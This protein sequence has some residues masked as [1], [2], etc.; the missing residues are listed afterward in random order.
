[1]AGAPPARMK[2]ISMSYEETPGASA[3]AAPGEP[4]VIDADIDHLVEPSNPLPPG[5]LA[6]FPEL[7]QAN[8][9]GAGWA[10]LM[11]VQAAAVPYLL[12]GDRD[13]MVQSRTGS[14]KTGAFVM[15]ILARLDPAIPH[16]QAL[17][18]VPTRELAV[19]VAREA[20]ILGAGMGL[21]VVTV[22][23]GVG[24]GTQLDGFKVGAHLV[25][26]TPGRILDHLMKRSLDFDDL[27]MLVFD[28]AD[29]MLSMGFYPDMV[30]LK[31]FLPRKRRGF[32]FSAT[33]PSQVLRLASQFLQQPEFLSLSRD[34]VHVSDIE[35]IYY[36]V[37]AMQKDRALVRIIEL[38]NPTSALIF[39]N[40][41]DKVNYVSTVLQRFGYDADQI[42]ADLPQKARERVLE[43]VRKGELR[44][45]VATDLAGRGIDIPNLSHVFLYE[46]PDDQESYIHRAGRTGRA[47][48]TGIAISLVSISEIGDLERVAKR[49]GVNMEKREVPT[50]E[51][52]SAVVSQRVTALLEQ[53][54]RGRDR[55]QVERMARFMPLAKSLSES[56]E[57]L[58]VLAMLLD[59]YYQ[60]T[61]HK[62]A[63]SS[64]GGKAAA[65]DDDDDRS[66]G[67]GGY[68]PNSGGYGGGSRD[69]GRGGPGGGGGGGGRGRKSGGSGGGSGSGSYGGGGS[70]PRPAVAPAPEVRSAS[71]G[72]HQD[73][74]A[75]EGADGP[76]KRRR[77]RGGR[78]GG[79]NAG[80]PGGAPE[81]GGG[82]G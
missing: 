75:A 21:N 61:L 39:C 41:K 27:K 17:V 24:Y 34:K 20:E 23:G 71:A 25:V 68:K 64:D 72:M 14:G 55:L 6:D 62:A 82:E 15:P 38:E 73:G 37:D 59:D 81:S 35:H 19:Q 76:K 47:G 22:Y 46:F 43:R 1:M 13:M 26:G 44:F 51:D 2:P 11:P 50:P 65:D 69:G 28:E 3:D 77:R 58:A 45:M 79:A 48:A 63:P 31:R 67:D 10:E 12:A 8:A 57:E 18:L 49:Y 40:R 78:G 9:R 80:G 70:A 66:G 60:E 36:E 53:K 32:M 4:A 52:V 29:R 5:K 7:I 30:A 56:D 54:L 42:S 74:S 16:C 33:F